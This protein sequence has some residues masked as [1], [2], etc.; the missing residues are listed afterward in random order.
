MQF[1][2]N[3]RNLREPPLSHF[4]EY[5]LKYIDT[6]WEM[7]FVLFLLFISE[8]SSNLIIAQ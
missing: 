3:L 8:S 5:L 1:I 4:D 7:G 2:S 6:V